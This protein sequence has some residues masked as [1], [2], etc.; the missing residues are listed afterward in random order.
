[1]PR[2]CWSLAALL[3]GHLRTAET[4]LERGAEL[5]WGYVSVFLSRSTVLSVTR[6]FVAHA[7]AAERKKRDISFFV[8]AARRGSLETTQLLLDAG[9]PFNLSLMGGWRALG[10]PRSPSSF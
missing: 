10:I 2:Q 3:A 1:M 7:T 6:F 8:M 5:D 9:V 4:L